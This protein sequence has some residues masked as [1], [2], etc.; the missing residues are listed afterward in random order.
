MVL[1]LASN[2]I[3]RVSSRCLQDHTLKFFVAGD[4]APHAVKKWVV[5]QSMRDLEPIVSSNL[6]FNSC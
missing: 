6:G 2:S 4:K 5:F 1:L 3:K